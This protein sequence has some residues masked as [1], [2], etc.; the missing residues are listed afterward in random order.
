MTGMAARITDPVAHPTPPIL[1][2]GPGSPDVLVGGLPAWRGVPTASAATMATDMAA[3]GSAKDAIASH[4]G[5]ADLHGCIHGAGVVIDGS[6]TVL[7]NGMPAAR[8]G[9][10]IIEPAGPPNKIVMGLPTVVIGD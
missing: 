2:G 9:D 6:A 8:M 7:I 1:T 5:T 10:T 3:G 4:A